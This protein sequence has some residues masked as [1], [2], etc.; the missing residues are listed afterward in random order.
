MVPHPASFIRRSLFKSIGLHDVSFRIAG[1]VEW[2]HR[3]AVAGSRFQEIPVVVANFHLGGISTH[4][5]TKRLCDKE[6]R[7]IQI[8]R[9][10][11]RY[12]CT[13]IQAIVGRK[14]Q[15]LQSQP[16]SRKGNVTGS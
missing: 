10:P 13:Q 8:R 3:A 1:D 6:V 9:F 15:F 11:I 16:K 5:A 4:A 2:M 7:R 14:M 12:A